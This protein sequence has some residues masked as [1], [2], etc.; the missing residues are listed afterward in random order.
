MKQ[1][2]NVH[3][4]LF[5]PWDTLDSPFYWGFSSS[6][7]DCQTF[8]TLSLWNGNTKLST[9]KKKTHLKHLN[10]SLLTKPDDKGNSLLYEGNLSPAYDQT[11]ISERTFW[12]RNNGMSSA[13]FDAI[14]VWCNL[15]PQPRPQGLLAFQYGGSRR[16]DP[17]T[18][19]KSRDWF[20]MISRPKYLIV[21][22][23]FFLSIYRMW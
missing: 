15:V 14:L 5:S 12:R 3:K 2:K 21:S 8:L 4:P 22:N 23:H 19:Q 7:L 10:N 6:A 18:Q 16:E 17:G 9:L 20:N 11:Y 1:L 13:L